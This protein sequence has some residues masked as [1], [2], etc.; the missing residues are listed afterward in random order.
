MDFIELGGIKHENRHHLWTLNLTDTRAF[1]TWLL[2][3]MV[4]YFLCCASCS[5]VCHLNKD[6]K[7]RV[8]YALKVFAFNIK[9]TGSSVCKVYD[10]TSA[11]GTPIITIDTDQNYGE[12]IY[13]IEFTT[14]LTIEI[15]GV[16]HLIYCSCLLKCFV[17]AWHLRLMQR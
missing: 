7:S 15:T 9:S 8:G 2:S 1:K 5:H 6:T 10:N 11:T 12:K 16:L 4:V 3:I 17:Y 13:N 14:G